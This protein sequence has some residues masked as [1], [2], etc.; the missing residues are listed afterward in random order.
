MENIKFTVTAA[1]GLHAR[2]TTV[3]VSTAAAFSSTIEIIYANKR[4]NI[5]SILAVMSLGV[6]AN[7][8]VEIELNGDDEAAA[9]TK[10]VQT[11]TDLQL[12][13]IN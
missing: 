3:L 6:P 7:A 8:E 12:G 13:S 11:I 4:S 1:E 9:K 10:L 2:P 5:K